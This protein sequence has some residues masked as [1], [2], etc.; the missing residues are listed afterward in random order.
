M[1]CI[2]HDTTLFYGR[3]YNLHTTLSNS[4]L[5]Y[6]ELNKSLVKTIGSFNVGEYLRNSQAPMRLVL[7][8]HTKETQLGKHKKRREQNETGVQV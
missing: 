7:K 4:S 3:T 2:M 5:L 8:I 1:I 6:G